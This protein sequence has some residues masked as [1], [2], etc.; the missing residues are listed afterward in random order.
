[1]TKLIYR[2]CSERILF[3]Y[4]VCLAIATEGD[5]CSRFGKV[6]QVTDGDWRFLWITGVDSEDVVAFTHC[7]GTVARYVR[8]ETRLCANVHLHRHNVIVQQLRHATIAYVHVNASR[9]V[10]AIKS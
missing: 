10:S 2:A 7:H 9:K 5:V 6:H 4:R 8:F 3:T 1:M